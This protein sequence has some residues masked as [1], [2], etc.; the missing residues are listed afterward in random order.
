MSRLKVCFL[1][2]VTFVLASSQPLL[3][4]ITGKILGTVTDPTGAVVVGATVTLRNS[5]TGLTRTVTTDTAGYQFLL[6]P[7][8]DGYSVEVGAAGFKSAVQTAITLLVNQDFKVD[9]HLEI[10]STTQSVQVTAAKLQVETTSTQLGDVIEDTKMTT[11]PLNGRSYIDLLGLQA[12]VVPVQSSAAIYQGNAQNVSGT[13][14][15]GMLSVDGA[16]ES[17]NSFMVNGGDVED[18]FQNG[19]SVVPTLDSIQEFRLLSNTNDAEYGRATGAIVNV[20]T[21]SGTNQLHGDAYDFVRNDKLDSRNFFDQNLIN[22]LTGQQIPNSAK[23]A[24]KQNQFGGT[25]GGPIKRDRLFFF[26]DYQGTRQ[27][28][29]ASSGII[30]VPSSS[31]RTGDFS[32][33]ATT[34]F[35]ALSGAVRGDDVPNSGSM[36][37]RLTQRLGYT[38]NNGEPYWVPGCSTAADAQ[39]GVC[40]FPNQVIPQAAMSPAALGTLKY[41]SVPTGTAAGAPFFSSTAYKGTVRDDKWAS[42]IDLNTQRTGNWGVYYHFD[43]ASVVNPYGGGN[44]GGFPLSSPTRAQQ[45][46]VSNTKN[47]GS[48]AINE[49]RFNYARNAMFLGKL[50]TGLGPIS[51]FGFVAGGLGIIPQNTALEEVPGISLFSTGDTF[52]NPGN[53]DAHDNTYQLTDNFSKITGPHTFKMGVD[54]RKLEINTDWGYHPDG[55]FGFVG[56]ETGNDFADY[57]LGTPDTFT[58]AS[59][60]IL[61][62]RSTYFGTYFQDSYKLKPNVTVNMGLRWEFSSPWADTQGRVETFVPGEQSKLYPDAPTGWVFPGDPGI[63]PGMSPTR[64]RNFGPRIGVAYSPGFADGPLGKLV[65]GPGKTSIRVAFGIYYTAFEEIEN[66]WEAG[67]PPFAQYWNSPDLIYLEEPYKGRN[68]P[69][70]GQRFPFVQYPPGTTGIWGQYQ[71]LNSTQGDNINNK[72]PY[73]EQYNL[74]IQRKL[75]NFAILTVG[76]V[77]NEGHHLLGLVESNPGNPQL[78]LSVSQPSEVMPGTPTCGPF[79]ENNIYTT[80]SGKMIYGT[81]P[82]SVTSGRYLSKGLLDFGDVV[83]QN[84]WANSNYNAL[85]LSLQRD[86]GDLH[87]LAAYTWSKAIDDGSGFNDAWMNPFNFKLTR[88]LSAYDAPQNFVVSYTYN[89]PFSKLAG[90]RRRLWD[91]WQISG[92]TRL[93]SGFPVS[94]TDSADPSLTG[95]G[96]G[97]VDFPNYNGQG[98]QILNPRATSDHEYFSTANFSAP[99]L[100]IEGTANRRFFFGPGLNNTDL[101]LHKITRVNERS[102]IEIRAEFFNIFNHAQFITPSGDYNSSVF[103]L[104]TSARAPRIGQLALKLTF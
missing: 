28:Y 59:P 8:G 26:L 81:R 7:I 66:M 32:D 97:G 53:W 14:F 75:G 57:L 3:A 88:S 74:S 20:V 82:Y 103:N 1:L 101:S 37:E 49:L 90:S 99:Q 85:Q 41:I 104:I 23:G 25:F 45:A 31:E 58:Q 48:T 54:F 73:A 86:V 76:Y 22:P 51:S 13:G 77:G 33:V 102:S 47:F 78:C 96:G 72:L 100:G 87:L 10:G 63:A 43:D 61:D 35:H 12:G 30:P 83:W 19:A 91:G 46:T 27:V 93:T 80:A 84:T 98:V 50:T 67:N 4:D 44:T 56:S 69:D 71:P 40:V 42:R 5:N 24:L 64:Y 92:I 6:V 95:I 39:A 52:G 34:G 2:T 94:L 79:G 15:E 9:F 18:N 38:V 17:G 89:L 55:T 29:G 65:G 11:M 68:G 21:K 36:N 70:P 16:R 62:D 60:A